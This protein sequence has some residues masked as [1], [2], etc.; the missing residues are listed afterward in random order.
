[1]TPF[2]YLVWNV[3]RGTHFDTHSCAVKAANKGY[4]HRNDPDMAVLRNYQ[5]LALLESD[6]AQWLDDNARGLDVCA[7]P[8]QYLARM[9]TINFERAQEEQ[10][11]DV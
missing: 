1:M 11:A 8:E 4:G 9:A 3:Y 7:D 2:I 6:V 5:D 10:L